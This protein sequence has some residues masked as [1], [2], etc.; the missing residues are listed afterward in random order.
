MWEQTDKQ[1]HVSE[2]A[3]GSQDTELVA[4]QFV[5]LPK[6]FPPQPE[7]A[8]L[9]ANDVRPKTLLWSI[10]GFMASIHSSHSEV[11]SHLWYYPAFIQKKE[12]INLITLLKSFIYNNWIMKLRNYYICRNHFQILRINILFSA[13][14]C[15]PLT[16]KEQITQRYRATGT[17]HLLV[18]T[19]WSSEFTVQTAN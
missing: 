9:W 14:T 11:M 1:W 15:V 19:S 7:T 8:T 12:Q 16:V 13:S 18:S 5:H 6:C 10:C 2:A 3:S 4:G 17:L